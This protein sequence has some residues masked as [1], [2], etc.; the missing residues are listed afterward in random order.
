MRRG[1]L[2]TGILGLIFGAACVAADIPT[3]QD[4]DSL[5]KHIRDNTAA[6]VIKDLW[7]TTIWSDL[8][9]RV[10]TGEPKWV[11]VAVALSAGSDAGATSELN[12]ALFAALLVNPEYVLSVLPGEP[13]NYNAVALSTICVGSTDPPDTYSAALAELKLAESAIQQVRLDALKIKRDLCLK[14]LVDGEADLKR[15]FG[16]GQ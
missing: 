7:G 5:L 3:L 16:V 11:D 6:A 1:A 12:D 13:S 4:A 15:F 14:K 9:S 10:A 8:V 2:R